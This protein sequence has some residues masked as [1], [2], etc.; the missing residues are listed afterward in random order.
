MTA[1]KSGISPFIHDM[2]LRLALLVAL[3]VATALL[4]I[5]ELHGSMPCQSADRPAGDLVRSH[6]AHMHDLG[7]P[8]T[9][10]IC[11]NVSMVM[12]TSSAALVA[13]LTSAV[14]VY[15]LFHRI[16]RA[17]TGLRAGTAFASVAAIAAAIATA[18]CG[19]LLTHTRPPS[20]ITLGAML[21]VLRYAFALH[22]IAIAVFGMPWLNERTSEGTLP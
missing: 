22:A 18:A 4:M 19:L 20:N 17:G 7:G 16:G 9:R 1:E 14:A 13:V 12:L 10:G 2:P 8:L 6:L 3:G 21:D 15:W 11:D 5:R